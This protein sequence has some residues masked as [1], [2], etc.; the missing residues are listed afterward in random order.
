MINEQV[1]NNSKF[2]NIILI[3]DEPH[4]FYFP[5]VLA[6]DYTIAEQLLM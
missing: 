6:R 5:G 4:F 1:L 2:I 3:S